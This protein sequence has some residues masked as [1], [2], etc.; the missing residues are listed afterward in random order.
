MIGETIR[1]L[2]FQLSEELGYKNFADLQRVYNR[3][4]DKEPEA[5]DLP[6]IFKTDSIPL[7]VE[8]F[9]RK[10]FKVKEGVAPSASF[11]DS[12]DENDPSVKL[13]KAESYIRVL[14]RINK[15]LEAQF[16]EKDLLLNIS[17]VA[18]NDAIA[19]LEKAMDKLEGAEIRFKA[20][21][22]S[23]ELAIEELQSN[24]EFQKLQVEHLKAELTK[25]AWR[26]KIPTRLDL[27]NY[28]EMGLASYGLWVMLG[29]AGFLLSILANAFYFD[30]QKTLKNQDA[31][32]SAS[33]A[34]FITFALSIGFGFVHFNT[35]MQ[36]L[37]DIQYNKF[38]TSSTLAVTVSGLSFA[39]L[40]QSRN[41]TTDGQ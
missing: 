14:Q 30:S 5:K 22:R 9:I 10:R 21:E 18:Y 27:I 40:W 32:E 31:W 38:W 39:A 15:E 35:F 13:G 28:T 20:L 8:T 3:A 19:D 41:K 26:L 24:I 12:E 29:A 7:E 25:Q 6:S 2:G 4:R 23:K 36:T 33:F 17:D 11:D 37:T 16:N 1:P 34:L